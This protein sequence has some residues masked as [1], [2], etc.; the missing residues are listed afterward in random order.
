MSYKTEAT[1]SNTQGA[2]NKRNRID[3]NLK[4]TSKSNDGRFKKHQLPLPIAVLSSL[5]IHQGRINRAGYWII[6]C[7]FHKDGNEKHPSLN[8]HQVR[9]N[10]ICHAC[11]AKGGDILSFFMQ[12]TGNNFIESAKLLGAWEYDE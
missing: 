9:G 5:N 4:R 8:L 3:Y 12:Y 11:G 10:F 7:P 6:S 2:A 1:P